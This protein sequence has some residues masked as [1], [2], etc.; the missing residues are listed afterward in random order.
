MQ[1]V[2]HNRSQIEMHRK[3]FLVSVSVFVCANDL[4]ERIKLDRAFSLK[5]PSAD[6][7]MNG[8]FRRV[9]IYIMHL[10]CGHCEK[11]APKPNAI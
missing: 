3:P 1:T 11:S 4:K 6:L 7:V 5:L 2:Q 8:H 9:S 10:H